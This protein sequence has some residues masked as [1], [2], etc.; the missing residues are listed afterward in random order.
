MKEGGKG[1]K[2]KNAI[3]AFKRYYEDYLFIAPFYLIFCVFTIFPVFAA[4]YYSFTN[5]NVLEPAKFL[6]FANYF[7]LF[8]SEKLFFQALKTTLVLAVLTGPLG[9]L[10]SFVIAWLITQF[11]PALR[12]LFTFIFYIPSMCGTAFV[13]WHVIFS[14][15]AYGIV[16]SVLL[17]LNLIYK[18]IQ[19]TVDT[20]VMMPVA[21]LIILWMSLGTGFLAFIAGLQNVDKA[22]YEAA[23]IDGIRN[24]WQE[25][26]FVTLPAMKNQ[27]MFGAIMSI[28]GAFGV[29][30]V[31]TQMFGNPSADYK[32]YT[33]M[34]LLQDYGGVRFQMGFASTISVV[35]FAIM[36]GTNLLVQ[37][38]LAKWSD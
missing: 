5:F 37:R 25:A 18:P 36:F 15:D 26:W 17:S 38:N 14:N 19:W 1:M 28:T 12:T 32:L 22:M 16:N 13:I 34:H 21:V 6:G 10:V 7:R 29:G 30:P 33:L 11:R 20:T 31:I 2:R 24:R 4:I 27:L 35:L 23:A 8:M 9:F 3:G